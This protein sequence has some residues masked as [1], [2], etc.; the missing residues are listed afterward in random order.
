MV[1]TPE[2]LDVIDLDKLRSK[3]MPEP[4]TGQRL[5]FD[6]RL[7]PVR[8]WTDGSRM[9]ERDVDRADLRRGARHSVV[10]AREATRNR[11]QRP[12]RDQCQTRCGA[13]TA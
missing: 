10:F 9:R 4:R 8:R 13:A 11:H 6:V 3:P 12:V 5:G 2:M 7:R 1:A